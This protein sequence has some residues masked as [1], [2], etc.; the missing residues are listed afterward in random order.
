MEV[1]QGGLNATRNTMRF[2]HQAS[3]NG[4]VVGRPHISFTGVE[5]KSILKEK[6][7]KNTFLVEVLFRGKVK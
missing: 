7:P 4:N 2:G 1:G 3:G 5:G 6:N